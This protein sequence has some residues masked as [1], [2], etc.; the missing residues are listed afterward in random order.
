MITIAFGG[1]TLVTNSA[2]WMENM[3]NLV[4]VPLLKSIRA[5]HSISN[6]MTTAAAAMVAAAARHSKPAPELVS[7]QFVT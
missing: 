4:V 5:F 2:T 3:V 1:C 6:K 7:D